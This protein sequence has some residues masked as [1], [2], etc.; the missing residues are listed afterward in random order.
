MK[1]Y[2]TPDPKRPWISVCH[3]DDL[4]ARVVVDF[5]EQTITI[6]HAGRRQTRS[7]ADYDAFTGDMRAFVIQQ[8]TP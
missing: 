4:M 1:I 5:A 8:I 3:L 2:D 6:R 7:L